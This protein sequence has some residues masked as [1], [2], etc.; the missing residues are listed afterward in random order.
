[1]FFCGKCKYF[2][3]RLLGLLCALLIQGWWCDGIDIVL[4]FVNIMT[5]MLKYNYFN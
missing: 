4:N 3:W 5:P 2:G 1:M